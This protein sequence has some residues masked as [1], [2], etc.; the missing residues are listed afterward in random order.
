[1]PS[2][3]GRRA[4]IYVRISLDPNGTRLGVTRQT[5]DCQRKAQERG[6][7]VHSIYEDNDTSASNGRPRPAYERMLADLE[8]GVI[9]AVVVWDLDRLTRRPIEI[10]HF[11]DLADRKQVALASVG[12][13]VDLATDNGRLFARI[14]GA[15]A[16]AEVERKSARQRAANTQRAEAGRP[17]AGRRAFGYTPDGAELVDAEAQHIRAAAEQLLAGGTIHAITAHLNAAGARTTAGNAWGTTEVRRMLR[18]PRYAGLRVHRGDVVG[19]GAWPIVLD[20]DTH[21]A[22]RA[23]L[24]DPSR[25]APGRPQSSLLTGIAACGTCEARIYATRSGPRPRLYY[26]STRAHL[27]RAAAPVDD[28]VTA[29]LLTR[30]QKGAPELLDGAA[31]EERVRAL[32]A[33]ERGL[34]ARL[35]GLAEAY[36]MEDIDELQLRAGS[37]RLRA[38]LEQVVAELTAARRRPAVSRLLAA[39]DMAAEW[40][41]MGLDARRAAVAATMPLLRLWPAG[42]GARVFRPATVTFD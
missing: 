15:V 3:T 2:P 30:L 36:G 10:E 38:E 14:K 6:W 13:D 35:D 25:R 41:G 34:R 31:D 32:G 11:I 42:R 22:V 8:G 37:R 26:C 27:S 21:R 18:N 28:Y 19:E 17:H 7:V 29:T 24:D 1:M 33:R 23:V 9:D 5:A 20:R 4:G 40:E 16:R 39:D 12:G